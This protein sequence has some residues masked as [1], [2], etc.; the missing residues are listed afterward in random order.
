MLYCG[1]IGGEVMLIAGDSIGIICCS[2]GKKH[3]DKE[4]IEKLEQILNDKF[5]LRAVFAETIFRTNDSPYSGTPKARATELLKLYSNPKI[6]AI[7]DISG[8]DAANQ[9]LP[10]LDFDSIRKA[11]VPFIGYSDLT[12]ILNAIYAKTK[13]I[14]YNYLLLNLVGEESEL[15]QVQFK[16]VFFENR[17][18]ING[19][20]LTDFDWHQA[21]VIGGNIRCFLKLAGTEFMP[22]FSGKLV[23]LESFGG[24]E[25]K[26]ASCL[27]QLEQ[28]GAFTKCSGIIVGQHS[29]AEK[30]GEYKEIGRLYQELGLKYKL[31]IFRTAEIGH[32]SAAK[33]CPIGAEIN[34]SRETLTNF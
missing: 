20:T 11:G 5:D 24:K 26:I 3:S 34:V 2:D 22:D 12:V 16:K 7:F 17:L 6:K 10:Y 8:G 4:K 1:K 23:L 21:D 18:L 28:L 9:I 14:G 13:Q 29:E 19:R 25:A 30:S 31:P 33:P 27:A 32:G 15:Q